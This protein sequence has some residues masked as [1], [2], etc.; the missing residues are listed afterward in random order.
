MGRIA[1][2]SADETKER[3]LATAAEVFATHGYDGASIADITAASG[4]S[5]G[6]IY[7]HFSGKAELFVAALRAHAET[8]FERLLGGD[9]TAGVA[10]F[11]TA[12]GELLDRDAASPRP[13]LLEALIA[14]TRHPDV[15]AVIT[16][17]LTRRERVLVELLTAEQELGA[18]DDAL[19]AAAVVRFALMAAL[20]SSI[21]AA[22]EL[23][24]VDHDDWT[25]LI[26]RLVDTLRPPPD[27]EEH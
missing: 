18:A 15:A 7:T 20:G 26:G 25:T 17:S 27:H 14:A 9:G 8:E 13:L 1:G 5:S 3:L 16:D 21:V 24:S 6:A 10:E 11:F 4:L 22:L 12:R 2:V 19:S 23:P